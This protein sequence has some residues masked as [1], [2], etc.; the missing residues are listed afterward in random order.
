MAT[1]TDHYEDLLADQY[2]WMLGGDIAP[3]AQEQAALLRGLGI[4]PDGPPGDTAI[5]LG[6][7]PGAQSLALAGLGFRS[8]TAYGPRRHPYRPAAHRRAWNGRRDRLHGRHAAPPPGRNRCDG[9]A[10]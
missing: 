2:T 8:V 1:A 10:R 9:A 6:C 5:D 4:S 7:G 3:L